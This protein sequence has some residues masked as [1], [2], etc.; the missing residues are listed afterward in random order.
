MFCRKCGC[1]LDDSSVACYKCG[2]PTGDG[3]DVAP[4]PAAPAAVVNVPNHLVA[5]ILTTIFCCLIGGIVSIIYSTQVNTKLAQGDIEGARSAS[6]KS[7][8][9][10]IGSICFYFA[11]MLIYLI[12]YVVLIAI[13]MASAAN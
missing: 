2:A 12:V 11:S 4:A 7:L 9:W 6:R 10:I 8:G 3:A 13:G 1:E 5:A